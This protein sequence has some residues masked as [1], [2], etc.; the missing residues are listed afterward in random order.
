MT[1]YNRDLLQEIIDKNVI[2]SGKFI[3]KS[4]IESSI[5]IDL[6]LL[7]NEPSTIKKIALEIYQK[8]NLPIK[9]DMNFNNTGDKKNKIKLCGVP[10]GALP[11]SCCTSTD[12]NIPQIIIRKES[13][14]YGT[15]K[16]IEGIYNEGDEL[17]IIE[18]IVTT[19]GSVLDLIAKLEQE[20]LKI[21]QI[22]VIVDRSDN[23]M[24]AI[25][26]KG[27]DIVSLFNL[28]NIQNELDQKSALE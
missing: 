14:S 5:Y 12:F 3:L 27:Y 16:L 17:I 2:K 23:N 28:S 19:G 11:F 9:L 15:K 10:Y 1:T 18:D 6:R 24:Q 20:N 7:L 26:D 25:K 8:I 22:I 13:K 4:G 21:R